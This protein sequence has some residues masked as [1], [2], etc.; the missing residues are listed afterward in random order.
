MTSDP[1]AAPVTE[2]HINQWQAYHRHETL[3]PRD[4]HD[5]PVLSFED[6]FLR[7]TGRKPASLFCDDS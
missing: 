2:Q 6:W 3:R 5:P 7:V 4:R 1:A